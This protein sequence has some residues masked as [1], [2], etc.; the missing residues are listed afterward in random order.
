MPPPPF[1]V[2]REDAHVA[3][4]AVD[5]ARRL[6]RDA[7][8]I[9]VIVGQDYLLALPAPLVSLFVRTFFQQVL[10]NL[11]DLD[12]LLTLPA[13]REHRA[14]APVV[15]VQRIIVPAR[16][17]GPAELADELLLALELLLIRILLHKRLLLLGGPIRNTLLADVGLD[18]DLFLSRRLRLLGGHAATV[19]NLVELGHQLIEL[20]LPESLVV[21]RK[22]VL[23]HLLVKLTHTVVG[24]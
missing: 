10:L 2:V 14:L 20:R 13:G 11:F 5:G 1:V 7:L 8:V 12:D 24:G 4:R 9:F 16:I 19:V 18:S 15:N 6:G 17:R 21:L 22:V 23:P 3:E